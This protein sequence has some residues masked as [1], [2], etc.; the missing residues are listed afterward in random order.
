MEQDPTQQPK[1]E[2]DKK[3]K[4]LDSNEDMFGHL[5]IDH[6]EARKLLDKQLEGHEKA[7]PEH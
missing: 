6:P 4:A 3:T 2:Q 5:D 1:K 7:K